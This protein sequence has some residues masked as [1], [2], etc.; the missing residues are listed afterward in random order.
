MMFLA[1]NQKGYYV[2]REQF[3]EKGKD[4]PGAMRQRYIA[5]VGK[6]PRLARSKALKICEEKG[7]KLQDLE[8]V[9]GLTIVDEPE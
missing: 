2:I 5:Y 3:W 9:R 1:K 4:G 6:E 8:A 7:I